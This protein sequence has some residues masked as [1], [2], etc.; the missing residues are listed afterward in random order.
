MMETPKECFSFKSS[1]PYP[2]RI[3]HIY[4]GDTVHAVIPYKGDL[5]RIICRLNG[6]DA[7][8]MVESSR[9]EALRS[10]NRLVQLVT[11]CPITLDTQLG[12]KT[13][14]FNDLISSNKRIIS[15]WILGRDKYGRELAELID[16]YNNSVNHIMLFEGFTKH[17]GSKN[18]A[19]YENIDSNS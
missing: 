18:T 12:S 9:V 3:C 8:E 4:D 6:I 10:R 19:I 11:D 7:P 2:C 5:V 14:E 13:R 16:E 17:Y 1:T 15:V